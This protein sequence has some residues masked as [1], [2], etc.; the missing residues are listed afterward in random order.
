MKLRSHLFK[1]WLHSHEEDTETVKVYRPEGYAFPPSRGRTGFDILEDGTL[2]HIGIA[3][4]NGSLEVIGHWEA[5][6]E[7]EL[8]VDLEGKRAYTLRISASDEDTLH[9]ER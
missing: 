6:S 7:S 4:T 3:P 9:I 2:I 5:I 1:R 8:V